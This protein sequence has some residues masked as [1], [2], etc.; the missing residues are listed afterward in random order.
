M[1]P[2]SIV[3][4]FPLRR[5]AILITRERDGEGW[6]ALAG[7]HGWLSGSL[8]AARYQ[9]KWLSRNFA[10]PVREIRA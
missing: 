10:V 8:D 3:I 4:R 6:L 5:V 7:S 1:T 2:A 9:A